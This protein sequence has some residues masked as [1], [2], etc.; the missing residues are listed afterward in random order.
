MSYKALVQTNIVP[1]EGLNWTS[2]G[3]SD[4]GVV[5]GGSGLVGA[6]VLGRPDSTA[7]DE[8]K[9]AETQSRDK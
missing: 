4:G 7:T 9:K 2:D 8:R 5:T 3:C 6:E 1:A